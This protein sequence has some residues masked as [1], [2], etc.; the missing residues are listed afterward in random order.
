MKIFSLIIILIFSSVGFAKAQIGGENIYPFLRLCISGNYASLGGFVPSA[1]FRGVNSVKA[2]PALLD[3]LD[4]KTLSLNYISYLADI[5]YG[6]FS[7]AGKIKN[8]II[9]AGGIDFFDYGDFLM[10]DISANELGHFTCKDHVFFFSAAKN[11]M[12]NF[13]LGLDAKTIFSKLEQYRSSAL[14]FDFGCVYNIENKKLTIG[15]TAKNFG[16]KLKSYTNSD[17]EKLPIELRLSV[18]KQLLYAPIKFSVTAHN[19]QKPKLDDDFFT[20]VADHFI[21]SLEVFPQGV[22]SVKAGF[23]FLTHNDLYVSGMSPFPGFSFGADLRLKKFS[24]Q[25]SRQC[26]AF[27]QN[28]NLFT[29]EIF[30]SSIPKR[31]SL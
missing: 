20:S 9:L 17:L 26:I 25:Y 2:N 15:F 3:S 4:D 10:T 22:F 19:L 16:F 11:L 27:S 30:F 8:A 29:A 24:V 28:S 31:K 1:D 14:C 21:I 23:N 18:S 13:S 7:Y 12:K 5:K 6:S